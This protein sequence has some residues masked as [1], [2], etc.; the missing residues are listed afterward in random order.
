MVRN[1]VKSCVRGVC[2]LVVGVLC[3]LGW[4]L[5]QVEECRC[6]RF[7]GLVKKRRRSEKCELVMVLSAVSEF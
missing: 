4:F 2:E 1:C 6:C 7:V 5:Q 3:W